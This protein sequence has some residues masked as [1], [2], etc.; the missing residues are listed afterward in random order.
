M[1]TAQEGQLVL[2]T[3]QDEKQFLFRLQ[4]GTRFH[5]HRGI[6]D[7][8]QIIDQPWG[9]EILSHLGFSYLILRPSI[10]DL[11][12]NLKRCTQI[13]YPKESAQILLKLD[14]GPGSRVIE[15]G[16]GSGALTMAL[17]HAVGPTGR[18]YSYEQRESMSNTA[19][20]NLERV[21]LEG[22]VELKVR[23]IGEG[24][25]E[26]DVDALFL[27][28]REPWLYLEQVSQALMSGGFFG[29]I[30]P[31]TNQVQELLVYMQRYRYI[32]IEVLE[33]L[34]RH[35]K[36]I[37]GRLRPTDR[38]VAHTGYLIFGRRTDRPLHGSPTISAEPASVEE[39]E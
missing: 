5:T 37:P 4:A 9:R 19:R 6:V 1:S 7:H 10:N 29:A 16:T 36:P 24:F 13:I 15:A 28:V 27:D 17:A 34:E 26:T 2:L 3:G 38:M 18:I 8:D 14:V 25:D 23:D 21:G 22:Q 35:Y 20:N 33:T 12:M 31:T 11:I 30:L 32:A 39:A